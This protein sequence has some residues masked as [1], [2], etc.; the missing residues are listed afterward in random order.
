VISAFR[1]AAAATLGTAL[2]AV[3]LSAMGA[4]PPAA[5]VDDGSIG[6]RPGHEADFF[7]LTAAPG[8][9][10]TATAVLSNHTARAVTLLTYPVDAV[11]STEGFA[12]A[13]RAA[14]RA[15]VGR[16]VELA[17]GEVTVPA[18]SEVKIP[19]TIRV[20]DDATPG[21]YAGAVIIQSPP[22]N[23]ATTTVGG[24]TAVR[25][26]VVQR[27][28]VRIYLKVDG[29]TT[30]SLTHGDLTWQKDGDALVFHLDLTN[31][32]TTILR[33]S[34]DLELALWGADAR[35]VRFRAPEQL[36]PGST[37]SL[38]ASVADAPPIGAGEA[39]A[40]VD[41]PA[42]TQRATT[43]LAFAPGELVAVAVL[44]VAA[45]LAGLAIRWTRRARASRS[46]TRRRTGA[47][48]V[49]PGARA[50]ARMSLPTP[51][52]RPR[53]VRGRHSALEPG[54]HPAV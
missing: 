49:P 35:R 39:V 47:T 45:V 52:P 5:A 54:K 17:S 27:Q 44:A 9:T 3:T 33:P 10:S 37:A 1:R 18:K 53:R 32:G 16:W 15:G 38:T 4:V 11:N 14:E 41:S 42:G 34:A 43:S 6:I 51:A 29:T 40:T 48:A 28:G 36:L 50:R 19:L 25:L 20:P 13:D 12:M 2:L 21:E 31:T 46:T 23:G 30:T 24:D 22:V 7:H 26:D 8:S